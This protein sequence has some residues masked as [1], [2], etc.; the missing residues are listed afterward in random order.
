MMNM[1]KGKTSTG[2][3]LGFSHRAP[4]ATGEK[5]A[6]MPVS[7]PPPNPEVDPKSVRRR[8]SA[9]Y[10]RSILNRADQCKHSGEVGALLR[11]EGLFSSHLSNWRRLR[12]QGAL[13]G[14]SSKKRGPKPDPV[15]EERRKIARLEKEN[16]RLQV[17]LKKAQT[18]IEFQK[19]LSEILE[20]P[21][22]SCQMDKTP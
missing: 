6:E 12:D 3:S 1:V 17:K 19:K 10:K 16:K 20:I 7:T 15:A 21:M 9:K 4:G 18:I 11:R 8:F 14:L 2:E 5:P 13:A 22:D